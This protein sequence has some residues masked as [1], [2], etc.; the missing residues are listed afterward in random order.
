MT[1]AFVLKHSWAFWLF[2]GSLSVML[3]IELVRAYRKR[4]RTDSR[5]NRMSSVF[6][7]AVISISILLAFVSMY[8]SWFTVSAAQF[9]LYVVGIALIW[10]GIA[11]RWYAVRY[12]GR[13]FSVDLEVREDHE[14]VDAGP[15]SHVRN[16]S[17]T[18]GLISFIG[19]GFAGNNPLSLAVLMVGTAVAYS[20]RIR[21]EEDVLRE[22]LGEEYEEYME[23][24]PYRLIPY[25]W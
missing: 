19:V 5:N 22:N 15:Y 23:E 13:Y 24:T 11:Y 9:W 4:G 17:Y 6:L 8:F 12:L 25:V 16:P 3:V 1:K 21:V 7:V 10:I 2:F 18:G 14:V 20:Y